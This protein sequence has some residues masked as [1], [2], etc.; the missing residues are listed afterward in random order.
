MNSATF[1]RTV[2]HLPFF[3]APLAVGLV[4]ADGGDR[5]LI[6]PEVTR[7]AAKSGKSPAGPGKRQNLSLRP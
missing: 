6:A 1:L 5:T 7:N 3:V 4:T 2:P